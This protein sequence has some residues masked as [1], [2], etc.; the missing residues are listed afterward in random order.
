MLFLSAKYFLIRC[1]VNDMEEIETI[2]MIWKL[3]QIFT[4]FQL[5]QMTRINNAHICCPCAIISTLCTFRGHSNQGENKYYF[6]LMIQMPKSR[7]CLHRWHH[8]T[9]PSKLSNISSLQSVK[10]SVNN[11]ICDRE[12]T[13]KSVRS[14]VIRYSCIICCTL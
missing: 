1:D 12:M 14:S 11:F 2:S 3:A 13:W 9:L 5:L 6:D 7:N 10:L 8:T 4:R